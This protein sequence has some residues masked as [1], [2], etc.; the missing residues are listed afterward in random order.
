MAT[1]LA[2][3]RT[4]FLQRFSA[5]IVVFG[6]WLTI[7]NYVGL[8]QEYWMLL[9]LIQ[10]GGIYFCLATVVQMQHM[11]LVDDQGSSTGISPRFTLRQMFAWMTAVAC[12]LG[13]VTVA[14]QS[15]RVSQLEYGAPR[16]ALALGMLFVPVMLVLVWAVLGSSRIVPMALAVLVVV[17]AGFGAG[18]VD[19]IVR[20]SWW[21]TLNRMEYTVAYWYWVFLYGGIVIL[22]LAVIR[23]CGYR[24]KRSA[25]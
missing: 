14:L 21:C 6:F 13:F 16:R 25:G 11:C 8:T 4:A 18:S 5:G 22:S 3:G 2:L 19:Q 12:V 24:L 15:P 7:L 20:R 23:G 1:W 10:A 9:L 17:A